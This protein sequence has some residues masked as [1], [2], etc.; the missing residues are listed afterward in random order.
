MGMAS[1]EALHSLL[2]DQPLKIQFLGKGNFGRWI[3]E[4]WAGEQNVSDWM[5]EN[6]HADEYEG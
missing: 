4:M 1:K 6:G 3:C 5:L 2:F